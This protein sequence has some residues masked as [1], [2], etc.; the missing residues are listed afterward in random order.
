MG[1]AQEEIFG[2]VVT[3][4]PFEDETEAV[5]IANDVKYG[6]TATVW[7]GIRDAATGSRARSSQG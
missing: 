5:R 7:T 6:L 4:I 2:P 1:V 3:I